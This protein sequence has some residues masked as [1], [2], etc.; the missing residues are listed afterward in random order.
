M[1]ELQ[2]LYGP[3]DIK[4]DKVQGSFKNRVLSYSSLNLY[5]PREPNLGAQLTLQPF[6]GRGELFFDI[7]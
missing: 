4:L 3:Y 5:I 2:K 6:R 7:G 1:R